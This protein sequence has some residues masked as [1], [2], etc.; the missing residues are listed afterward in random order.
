MTKQK[1]DHEK[2]F[3]LLKSLDSPYLI[4]LIGDNFNYD[5]FY[6]FVIELCKVIP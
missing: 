4:Q 1:N 6:C 5:G 3:E 2:E